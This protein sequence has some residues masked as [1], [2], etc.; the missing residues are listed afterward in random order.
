VCDAVWCS[1]VQYNTQVHQG[2]GGGG[3][4]S[5]DGGREGGVRKNS[6]SQ[7]FFMTFP[8][9]LLFL[10]SVLTYRACL[11]CPSINQRVFL[12]FFLLGV[13][14][15]GEGCLKGNFESVECRVQGLSHSGNIHA[16]MGL[17]F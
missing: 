8:C 5:E 17:C 3:G 13:P 14:F 7:G 2:G 16:K 11:P 1:R 6:S 15:A 4:L 9:F 12:S 10:F